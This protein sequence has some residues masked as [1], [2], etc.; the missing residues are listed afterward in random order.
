MKNDLT[1]HQPAHEFSALLCEL[2][3]GYSDVSDRITIKF[4]STSN[5]VRFSCESGDHK[6]A[7]ATAYKD[8]IGAFRISRAAELNNPDL[9]RFAERELGCIE[10]IKPCLQPLPRFLQ[11]KAEEHMGVK[12]YE[13]K[14]GKKSSMWIMD[15][16][17]EQWLIFVDDAGYTD[18]E[19]EGWGS[20]DGS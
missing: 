2:T 19:D 1:P 4:G 10:S 11:W 7:A 13:G 18:W 12:L 20:Q 8:S 6:D 15:N 5:V 17:V 14:K 16:L 9:Q 3:N